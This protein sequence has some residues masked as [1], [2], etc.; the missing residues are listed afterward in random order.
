MY[1][2]NF[3]DRPWNHF[4]FIN[5]TAFGFQYILGMNMNIAIIFSCYTWL[6]QIQ[7]NMIFKIVGQRPMLRGYQLTH[8][9]LNSR[10]FLGY[11]DETKLNLGYT[12]MTILLK[13]PRFGFTFGFKS[14]IAQ[15]RIWW[16]YLVVV[17]LKDLTLNYTIRKSKF[18]YSI[19]I[20]IANY[21]Q[22]FLWC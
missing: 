15:N 1:T 21:V 13:R 22:T 14:W 20:D 18:G 5:I 6:N 9:H 8:W 11:V 4:E 3:H 10:E 16:P 2:C 12:Y 17:K 7:R 19:L